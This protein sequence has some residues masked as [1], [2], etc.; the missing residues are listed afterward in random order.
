MGDDTDQNNVV[1]TSSEEWI[2][3]PPSVTSFINPK[4]ARINIMDRFEVIQTLGNGM[5]SSVFEVNYIPTGQKCALKRLRRSQKHSD[6]LFV[7][8]CKFL[9]ELKCQGVIRIIDTFAD[10]NY[11][12]VLNE[13][14]VTDL[15]KKIKASQKLSEKVTKEVIRYLLQTIKELHQNNIV[16]RDIKPE[17]VVFTDK[18]SN[19]PKL[20]DFGDA[21]MVKHDNVYSEFVGTPCYLA[22]ER[23]RQHNG[24]ELKAADIWAI[25]VLTFE[26]MTG[27]RCF[28]ASS[29]QRLAKKIQQGYL[30][31]PKELRQS[32]LCC[33]FIRSLLTVNSHDRPTA[34]FAL[35]HPWLSDYDNIQVLSSLVEQWNINATTAPNW[36][37]Y[38]P[39]SF[40]DVL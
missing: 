34:E 22:P 5:S 21:M 27:R 9:N 12:Y 25:G 2:E 23:W 20:I 40:S 14:G 28:Y 6:L 38:K 33:H 17:N 10:S 32:K 4:K 11:F 26:V 29:D 7:G 8:E 13:L 1:E 30:K 15:F 39:D 24:W 16:H 37:V 35:Q 18:Q 36:T 3:V 31:Y 19:F